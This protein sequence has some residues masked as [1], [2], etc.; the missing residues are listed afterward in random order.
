MTRYRKIRK[1]IDKVSKLAN[2][3]VSNETA[4]EI[5]KAV[6]KTGNIEQLE[7]MMK[8]MMKK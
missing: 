5:I 1:L 8:M 4:N 6:K 3:P 7:N 2:I